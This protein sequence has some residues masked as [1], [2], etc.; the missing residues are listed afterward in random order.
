MNHKDPFLIWLNEMIPMTQAMGITSCD[1]SEGGLSLSAPLDP[2]KNDKGTGFAGATTALATLAG[3][4]LITRYTQSLNLD[5]EAMV[6]ESQAKYLRPVTQDF[7]AK[8]QLPSEEI[9]QEFQQQLK[10]KGRARMLLEVVITEKDQPALI[11][12][13]SYL[14][15]LKA[16]NL[17]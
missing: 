17:Q 4:S 6:V 15:R 10:Q 3:W 9:C 11:L 7:T 16:A 1:Y 12:Q 2:N 5:C 13:G 14:A 8:V